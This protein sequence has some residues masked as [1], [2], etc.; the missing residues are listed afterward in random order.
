MSP[1]LHGY[2]FG[3]ANTKS[4]TQRFPLLRQQR[5]WA[6]VHVGATAGTDARWRGVPAPRRG[7]PQTVNR[8]RLHE[9]Q[10]AARGR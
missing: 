4:P 6:T 9:Q 5:P 1:V 8:T 10:Q 7:V 2:G 3:M